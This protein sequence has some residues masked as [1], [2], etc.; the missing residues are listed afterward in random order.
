[1]RYYL[2]D[3]RNPLYVPSEFP[4]SYHAISDR[5]RKDEANGWAYVF[6][7]RWELLAPQIMRLATLRTKAGALLSDDC[8]ESLEA[9]AR[10]ARQLHGFFQNRVEQIRKGPDIVA[11]WADQDWVQYVKASVEAISG[12]HTDKYSLEFE[13]KF[14]ALK[15]LI[16][17]FI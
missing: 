4:A 14:E 7:N 8:A 13:A 11:P 1:M 16:E 2:Y 5:T 17:P 10:K 12:D 6:Q 9:L 3:A 15:K